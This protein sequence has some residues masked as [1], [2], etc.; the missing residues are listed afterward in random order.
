[1]GRSSTHYPRESLK[2]FRFLITKTGPS[3]FLGHLEWKEAI[4]RSLRRAE[5]PLAFSQGFHPL[6]RLSFGP[7][8]PV[9][10]SS[11]GEFIDIQLLNWPN[12]ESIKTRLPEE[13]FPGTRIVSITEVPLNSS[14]PQ[15][16]CYQY[17][18][19]LDKLL[20]DVERVKAFLSSTY[21]PVEKTN[22][23]SEPFNLRPMIR[24]MTLLPENNGTFILT[25]TLEPSPEGEIRP[26]LV[27]KSVF[28]LPDEVSQGLM[29]V[30]SLAVSE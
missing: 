17:Q 11:L 22:K 5:L 21:W 16:Q 7:A 15:K 8:L 12:V 30:K 4:I 3:R 23:K 28:D 18:V 2:K 14:L 24:S 9:G 1:M 26:E 25:W 20:A 27:L 19:E 29:V 13:L 10:I 6:P